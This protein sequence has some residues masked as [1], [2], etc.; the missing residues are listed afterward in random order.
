MIPFLRYPGKGKTVKKEIRSVV[1]RCW[2]WGQGNHNNVKGG[3]I[4]KMMEILSVLTEV[5]FT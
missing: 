2:A 1:A 5:V 4:W 3:N